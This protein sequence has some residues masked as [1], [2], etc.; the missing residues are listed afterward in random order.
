VALVR[1]WQRLGLVEIASETMPAGRVVHR[2][3]RTKADFQPGWFDPP[4]A[5]PP[6]PPARRDPAALLGGA[7]Q[8]ADFAVKGDEHPDWIRFAALSLADELGGPGEL[9]KD[10]AFSASLVLRAVAELLDPEGNSARRAK[11]GWRTP[12]RQATGQRWDRILSEHAAANAV[13]SRAA[14][15]KK[16]AAIAAASSASGI[17]D[18]IIKKRLAQHKRIGSWASDKA[19]AEA[20][21]LVVAMK[22]GGLTEEAALAEIAKATEQGAAVIRKALVKHNNLE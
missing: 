12:G 13:E 9:S 16:G 7:G 2:F 1:G 20:A 15:E 5:G 3:R 8:M 14:G 21:Q 18:G 10:A 4:P 11:I 17:S 6:Q 19:A 22:Q